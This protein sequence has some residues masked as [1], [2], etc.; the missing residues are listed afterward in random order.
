MVKN[1]ASRSGRTAVFVAASIASMPAIRE[2]ALLMPDAHPDRPVEHFV[3]LLDIGDPF[4][5][6]PRAAFA[7]LKTGQA[8]EG[9]P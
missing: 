5:S 8:G 6:G 2:L 3:Q 9:P 7:A 1:R 4:P